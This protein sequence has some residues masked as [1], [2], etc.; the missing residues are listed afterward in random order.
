V[1]YG[2][3]A[4]LMVRGQKAWMFKEV[5]APLL[6]WEV[7][8]RKDQFYR[9]VG[10]AL[11]SNATKLTAITEKADDDSSYT[12]TPLRYSLEAFISNSFNHQSAVTDF[13]DLYGGDDQ[14]AL[15]EYLNEMNEKKV[16]ASGIVEGYQATVQVIAANQ[17]IRERRRVELKPEWFELG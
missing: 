5:D 8:A 6:G 16:A 12:D 2:T 13:I 1:Y 11:V 17:A 14:E 4:A 7:Y 9:E 3:D 10:I 15:V